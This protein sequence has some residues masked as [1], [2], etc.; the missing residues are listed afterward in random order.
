MTHTDWLIKN[1][2]CANVKINDFLIIY[3]N[4]SFLV[5]TIGF[6]KIRIKFLSM[7]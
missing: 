2:E 3:S 1:S 7:I 6:K 5:K 4:F